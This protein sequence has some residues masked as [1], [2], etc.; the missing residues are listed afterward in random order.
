ML[1]SVSFHERCNTAALLLEIFRTLITWLYVFGK[2]L[3]C[4][5]FD[6][7]SYFVFILPCV[8]CM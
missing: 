7:L 6:L 5:S 8:C 3:R 4:K 1:Y 2:I